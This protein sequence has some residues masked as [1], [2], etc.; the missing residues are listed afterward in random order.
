[1]GGGVVDGGGGYAGEERR[2]GEEG[3]EDHR[4]G[5]ERDVRCGAE[6]R[7]CGDARSWGMR[8][9]ERRCYQIEGCWLRDRLKSVGRSHLIAC[10]FRSLIA[11]HAQGWRLHLPDRDAMQN[12]CAVAI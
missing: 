9:T 6:P 12:A 4:V 2:G 8:D 1:L 7:R 5:L 3:G 10:P 11:I